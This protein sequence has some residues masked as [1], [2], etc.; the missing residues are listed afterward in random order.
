[1]RKGVKAFS[2]Y[3]IVA[4]SQI[5]ELKYLYKLLLFI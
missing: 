5:K 1:M 3:E 4:K 2:A